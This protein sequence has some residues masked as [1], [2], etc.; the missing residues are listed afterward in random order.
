MESEQQIWDFQIRVHYLPRDELQSGHDLNERNILY[1][2]LHNFIYT[3]IKE[4]S[5][6]ISVYQMCTFLDIIFVSDT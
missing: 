6:P 2:Q 3:F 4:R 1:L 5:T